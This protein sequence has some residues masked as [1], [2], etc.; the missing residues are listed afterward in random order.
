MNTRLHGDQNLEAADCVTYLGNASISDK[1]HKKKERE[2]EDA[3]VAGHQNAFV[4]PELQ[5]AYVG[6][7]LRSKQGQRQCCMDAA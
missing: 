3:E 1:H 7:L 4:D 5:G 2:H 6:V